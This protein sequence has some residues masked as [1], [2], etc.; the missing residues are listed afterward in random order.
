MR[1]FWSDVSFMISVCNC[2]IETIGRRSKGFK[3][4]QFGSD[5]G[6]LPYGNSF[7]TA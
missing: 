1:V 3:S 2:N 5:I 6:E 7:V 4:G